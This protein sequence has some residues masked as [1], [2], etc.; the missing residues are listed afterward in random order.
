MDLSFGEFSRLEAEHIGLLL[1][2]QTTLLD[3]CCC[4]KEL[5]IT[6]L[7]LVPCV[8]E[9]ILRRDTQRHDHTIVLRWLP[10]GLRQIKLLKLPLLEEGGVTTNN[11]R[12]TCVQV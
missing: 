8:L 10:S 7:V 5:L 9:L 11:V 2:Y 3:V 4:L 12:V 1:R 6:I